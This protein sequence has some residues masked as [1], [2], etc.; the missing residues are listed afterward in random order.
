M[1]LAVVLLAVFVVPT[2]IS[3][4]AVALPAIGADLHAGPAASQ[5]VVNAFNVAFA[6]CTLVWGSLADLIGRVR[7]FAIGAAVFTAA[8]LACAVT[9]NVYVLDTARAVSG[10]GG[11]A[12]FA[13]GSAIISTAFDGAARAKAFA[14]FGTVAGVGVALGPTVSGPAV[15]LLGWRWIFGLHA[16]A[17]G[18]VLVCLPAVARTAGETRTGAAP[19]LDVRGAAVF[20]LAM[21]ALTYAIVQGSQWGWTAPGT[22]GLLVAALALLVLFT[23]RSKRTPAPLLDLSV[24][25]DKAF[26]AYCLV[27]VAASFGFVTQL[28]Y[29]PT[30]LTTVAGHS[31]S[32][33]GATM[34][35]LTLPVL[36]LPLAGAKLVERGASARGVVLASLG[37]LVA[38][39]LALLLLGPDTSTLVMAAPMLLTGAG[40]GLSAGLV[41]ARAL[42]LVD[43]AK[44]GMA[45]GFLNTLRLGSEAVAVAVFGSAV[46]GLVAGRQ[47]TGTA[48]AAAYD[49]AFHALLWAMA[50]V[51]AVLAL[52][53][54]ALAR[55]ERRA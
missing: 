18:L 2:S 12:I 23:V 25:R 48:P 45:A 33:A 8:S 42:A 54:V 52:A 5:W 13:C 10:V 44:A 22:L 29:L 50:A 32:S 55:G 43:P 19:R 37:F 11:A 53:V 16:L 47:A 24:V 46:A 38:G 21:L 35:L 41:D 17:L 20:V 31:P 28:T 6:C 36:V 49:S 9:P 4:T 14:L 51:C 30:Y 3:G 27:P 7:A 39:D 34:L 26:L 15:D 40:M 1:T